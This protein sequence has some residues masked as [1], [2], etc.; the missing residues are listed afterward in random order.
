MNE[1]NKYLSFLRKYRFTVIVVPVIVIIITYFLVRNL[2]TSYVSQAQITSGIVDETQQQS[3][4]IEA[5]QG[6]QVSQ[7]FSNL[8]EMMKLK[9]VLDQVSYQLIIHDLTTPQPFKPKSK[10]F[11]S[12][13]KSASEHALKVYMEKYAKAESLNLS[14]K[15]QNGLFLVLKSMRYDA[16][17]IK[18]KLL[19]YRSGDSDFILVQFESENPELSAF[20]VNTLSSEFIK[21]YT[22]VLRNNQIKAHNFLR[23]LLKEKSDTLADKMAALRNYKIRNRVL[24][25][26][27]QS[28]QLYERILEYDGK[29]Q[30]AIEKTAS[31]AGA[32]NEIDRKFDPRERKYIESALSKVN[33]S[34]VNT[35]DELNSVYNMYINSDLDEKYKNAYDSLRNKLNREIDRSSD[36]YITNPL[37]TKQELITQKLN[38]EIQMDLSRYSIN[39]LENKIN[40]LNG[41]FDKLVPSE[42]DV[43]TLE[44][45]V[46]IAS[47]E[48]LDILNRYNQSSLESSFSA[49]M[50]VVQPGTPG[51]AQPSKKML[52]VILSGI[53]SFVFCLL[54]IF[55]IYFFD[56]SV[57]S[58]KELAD[59]SGVPVF[60]NINYLNMPSL[61]VKEIWQKSTLPASLQELKNELRSMRYEMEKELKGKVLLVNSLRPGEGKSFITMSM[62]FAWMMMNKKVLVI[63]GNFNHLNASNNGFVYLEDILKG[64]RPVSLLSDE[65]SLKLLKNKGGNSS[66]LELADKATVD[67]KFDELKQFFDIIIIE[68]PAL[69]SLNQAKEWMLFADGIISVFES[70]YEIGEEEKQQISYLK[71]TGIFMGWIMN[72]VVSKKTL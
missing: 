14:D 37:N 26:T 35:R 66:I 71:Q 39:S 61:D 31:Y 36:Q 30:E 42:A 49:K 5:V 51:M 3:A 7:Q 1:V 69:G 9:R 60:G 45:N 38:L 11:A 70:G 21:N 58:A 40:S 12:L 27:E 18:E 22:S 4:L 57:V 19:I 72:K 59:Q 24:N 55:I 48:Y 62:A 23:D 29:K 65:V 53:I 54:V 52:L 44:L 2:P 25:L 34:I 13:N 63:D 6:D 56:T 10:L 20:V 64:S 43:Q 32:L 41:Q 50:D 16:E 15:D 33:Q 68:T 67:A 46:D 47:K 8:I 28:K 17:S